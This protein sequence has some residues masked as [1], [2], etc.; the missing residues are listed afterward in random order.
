[1]LTHNIKMNK[2]ERIYSSLYKK[3]GP[4]GW[5]P[6]LELNIKG[7]NPTKT[8]SMKGYH[9]GDYSYPCTEKQRFEICVGAILTQNTSWI[10]AEKSLSNLNSA[11]ILNPKSI[12][13]IERGKLASLIKPAGYFN[14]KSRKLK[15]FSDFY[16][17]LKGKIPSRE[18]LL[19][20]WGIGEETADSMLLYAFKIP[21]FVVDAY[22]KR[23]FSAL[24]IINKNA[25]YSEIKPLFES[26]IKKNLEIYQEYH[27]LIVEHGKR[28]ME[29]NNQA[30][31]AADLHL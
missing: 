30:A 22:T 19:N 12:I 28:I 21:T 25:K 2:I 14:Q 6:L 15:E 8:G 10:Q 20:V 18:Q 27:A 29:K 13:E 11:K 26:S 23:I 3:Y 16:F 9:P 4:Q 5:W 31:F 17:G 7:V 1:M 24:G